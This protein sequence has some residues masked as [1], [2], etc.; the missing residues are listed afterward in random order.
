MNIYESPIFTVTFND[1]LLHLVLDTGATSSL[2]SE[3]KCKE[4]EL[5]I[6]PTLHRAIQ[7]DGAKLNVVGEIHT[8]VKRDKIELKFSA[9]VVRT[10]ATE[11]LGEQDST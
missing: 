8:M 6:Y 5:H 9:I 4:L 3:Q 11:A 1:K 2:I 7:V 10:M